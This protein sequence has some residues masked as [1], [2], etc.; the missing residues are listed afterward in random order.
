M[1]PVILKLIVQTVVLF[2]LIAAALF[3]SAGTVKWVEG[4]LFFG[5]FFL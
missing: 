5:A 3:V 4:W 1:K 2:G